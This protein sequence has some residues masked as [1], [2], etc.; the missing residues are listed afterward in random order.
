[1]CRRFFILAIKKLAFN[2]LTQRIFDF[3]ERY[4]PFNML[5]SEEL[6]EVSSRIEV[7]YFEKNE[8]VFSAGELPKSLFFTVA[9]GAV[10]LY[11]N[12]HP[13]EILLDLCDEG[14][15]F[16]LRPLINAEKYLLTAKTV[17][18]AL[19]Y[20]VPIETFKKIYDQN[21]R[22]SNYLIS[23][24]ASYHPTSET[25]MPQLTQPVTAETGDL[26]NLKEADI[27]KKPAMCTSNT[28]IAEAARL[29][30]IKKMGCLVVTKGDKPIGIITDRDIRSKIALGTFDV[31]LPVSELMSVPVKTFSQGITVAEAQMAMLNYSIGHLCITKDGTPQTKVK[32]VISD[33]DLMVIQGSSPTVLMREIKRTKNIKSL[34]FIRQTANKLLESYLHQKIPILLISKIISEINDGI[35][36]RVIELAL[37]NQPP[38]PVTFA[39]LTIGSQGRQEQLLLTDQDHAL[40]FENVIPE[41]YESTKNY[42]LQLAKEI[43]KGLH[44]IGFEYCGAGMMASDPRWC[45]SLEEWQKQFHRWI[46]EPG[47]EEIM[48]S[49]IFFDYRPVYGNMELVTALTDF[50][51]TRLDKNEIFL[52]S[53][54]NNTLRKPTPLGFFRQFLLE[55]DGQY[56]E[57]FDIKVRALMPLIDAARMLI[58]E[59]GTRSF[60][61]TIQRFEKLCELEPKNVDLYKECIEAFKVFLYYRTQQGLANHN[62][63]R[64]IDLGTLSKMDKVILK[65]SFSAISD[66]Q[67]VLKIRFKLYYF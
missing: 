9:E 20:G 28:S 39:W 63:G 57:T 4:P 17:E 14:D 67:E 62:T 48:M 5:T 46:K 32:G 45:L 42:F 43:A 1:M 61:N 6:H 44:L 27:M 7:M 37:E 25:A 59:H 22:V 49:S 21:P 41:N 51:L 8:V 13:T 60:N 16:G 54:G 30:T 35:I 64:F 23:C 2:S 47:D 29:M 3:L 40:V 31:S 11:G 53:L 19:L 18:D 52:T 50:I 36:K 15:V 66:I 12:Q 34:K 65:N 58:L 10:A 26:I 55:K 38:P 24:F 56:K 33:R